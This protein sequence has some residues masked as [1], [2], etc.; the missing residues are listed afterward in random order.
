[1][2]ISASYGGIYQI[3]DFIPNPSGPNI[4]PAAPTRPAAKKLPARGPRQARA[5]SRPSPTDLWRCLQ[6]PCQYCPWAVPGPWLASSFTGQGPGP[7]LPM[8]EAIAMSDN[9]IYVNL[10]TQC[11]Q[12]LTCFRDGANKGRKR[13]LLIIKHLSERRKGE[14]T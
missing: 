10:A 11:F 1:L 13:K 9:K 12:S 3:Y 2:A 8:V 7:L 14:R 4:G 6:Q 5:F